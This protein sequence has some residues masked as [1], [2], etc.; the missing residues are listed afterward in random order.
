MK[1]DAARPPARPPAR[2]CVRACAAT[3]ARARRRVAGRDFPHG[4]LARVIADRLSLSF[5]ARSR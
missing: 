2:A 3:A 1:L 5:L 4:D